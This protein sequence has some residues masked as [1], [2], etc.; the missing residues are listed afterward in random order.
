MLTT[1][2]LYL[3]ILVAPS[4]AFALVL[5]LQRWVKSLST[6]SGSTPATT[7]DLVLATS[8]G[9]SK[10]TWDDIASNAN[11][12]VAYVLPIIT[13]VSILLLA[14]WPFAYLGWAVIRMDPDPGWGNQVPPWF[15]NP[16]YFLSFGFVGVMTALAGTFTVGALAFGLHTLGKCILWPEVCACGETESGEP[17]TAARDA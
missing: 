16:G 8:A 4:L 11:P 15:G 12:W 9:R 7:T 6:S 14:L 10:L 13:G 17:E 3:P 2:L 1:F 5:I